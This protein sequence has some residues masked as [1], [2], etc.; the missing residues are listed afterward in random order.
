VKERPVL[1]SAPMVRALLEGRKTQTRRLVKFA[2]AAEVD[3]WADCGDGLWE[4]GFHAGGGSV[5]GMGRIRCPYG[6][7]GDLL[8]V[9]E[10]WAAPNEDVRDEVVYR[11]DFP[12]G[13]E[14]DERAVKRMARTVMVPWKPSIHMPR[15]ASRITLEVTDVRVQRL[16]DISRDDAISEGFTAD[17]MPGVLIR[18]GK[19]EP[20]T[21]SF[22]DPLA[23]YAHLWDAINGS[24]SWK[25]NPWVWAISFKPTPPT[26]G[27]GGRGEGRE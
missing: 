8:W 10:T 15:W 16:Q 26:E 11:A 25:A 7:A 12:A 20:T 1:F 5:A 23:W 3:A 18:D 21:V 24:G 17:P 19:K 13:S 6:L 4:V 14:A 9:R 27:A 22:F 2:H